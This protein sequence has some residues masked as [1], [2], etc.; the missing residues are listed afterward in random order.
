MDFP[1]VMVDP[2]EE[3]DPL[4]IKHQLVK[5]ENEV[6]CV[7]VCAPAY[8]CAPLITVFNTLCSGITSVVI[9]HN[10]QQVLFGPSLW[11]KEVVL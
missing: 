5:A 6:S 10:V 4:S 3:E 1:G 9:M 2:K 8:C 7:R 11:T